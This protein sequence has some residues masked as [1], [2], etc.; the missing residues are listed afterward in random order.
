[1]ATHYLSSAAGFGYEAA[2]RAAV[3]VRARQ[4]V[5]AI[6]LNKPRVSP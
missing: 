1:M 5:T 4:H 3:W 6:Y 2:E